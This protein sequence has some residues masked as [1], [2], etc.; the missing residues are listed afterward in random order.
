MVTFPDPRNERF[1]RLK[2]LRILLKR[3]KEALATINTKLLDHHDTSPI[4]IVR[5]AEEFQQLWEKEA[6]MEFEAMSAEEKCQ[7]IERIFNDQVEKV[8][9][10]LAIV[11]TICC[12]TT[13]IASC[14]ID[15]RSVI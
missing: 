6:W 10:I 12:S 9:T 8:S 15:R 14:S 7:I 13:F 3:D 4:V 11:S 2:N 1:Y 5:G